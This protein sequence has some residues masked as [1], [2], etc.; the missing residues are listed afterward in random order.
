MPASTKDRPAYRWSVE[1]SVYLAPESRG[2]GLG[3]MLYG[4]LLEEAGNWGFATAYAGIAQ[5]N[6]VSEALHSA[7]G[8]EPI[9]VF[10]RAGFKLGEWRDVS[11][12]QRPLATVTP[13][14]PPA[15]PV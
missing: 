15:R 6:P 11:W 13:P 3:R 14:L 2:Q 8:F 4:A 10:R 5:P 1:T 9:G 12:W 7:V